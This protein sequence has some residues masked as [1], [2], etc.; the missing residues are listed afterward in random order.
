MR[1][2]LHSCPVLTL[3]V[4]EWLA[5]IFNKPGKYFQSTDFHLKCWANY[6]CCG[7]P[8]CVALRWEKCR[9]FETRPSR[10]KILVLE[11]KW[12]FFCLERNSRWSFYM[13]VNQSLPF[14]S[15]K[16]FRS[17]EELKIASMSDCSSAQVSV[18]SETVLCL[19]QNNIYVSDFLKSFFFFFLWRKL[20]NARL[21][22]LL[23]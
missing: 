15:I 21:M 13:L 10:L 9:V 22:R 1:F 2:Q 20:S 12:G 8:L 4:S 11:K 17:I 16:H 19:I 5:L 23:Q 6:L 18:R 7:T 3:I 14:Q